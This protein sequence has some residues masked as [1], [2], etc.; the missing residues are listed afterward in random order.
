MR[1]AA[2]RERLVTIAKS[3]RVRYP[4]TGDTHVHGRSSEVSG[5]DGTAGVA[6]GLQYLPPS[7]PAARTSR[8]FIVNGPA[9]LPGRLEHS[10]ENQVEEC[11]GGQLLLG[12]RSP[13]PPP[14][15]EVVVPRQQ[16]SLQCSYPRAPRVVRGDHYT[17]NRP[18]GPA[19]RRSE[20][21]GDVLLRYAQF[22]RFLH[23]IVSAT[24]CDS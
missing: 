21:G 20:N 24:Q 15:E 2:S 7:R 19:L 3:R 16:A 6:P 22:H 5:C 12:V 11:R 8:R 1:N 10:R 23:Y 17:P 9:L 18:E 14:G 13:Y 4:R